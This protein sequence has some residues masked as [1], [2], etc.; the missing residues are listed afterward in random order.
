MARLGR[1]RL[2]QR[3]DGVARATGH[4]VGVMPSRQSASGLRGARCNIS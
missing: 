2:L 3:L 1:Q 4:D